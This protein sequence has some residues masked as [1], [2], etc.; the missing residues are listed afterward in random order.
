MMTVAVSQCGANRAQCISQ[1]GG[2]ACG[3]LPLETG[4]ELTYLSFLASGFTHGAIF[5]SLLAY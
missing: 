3:F 5:L 2:L 1:V 4:I